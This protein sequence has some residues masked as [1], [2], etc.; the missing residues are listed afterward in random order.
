MSNFSTLN[1]CARPTLG[2]ARM[3][4]KK[5]ASAVS[6]RLVIKRLSVVAANTRVIV[7]FFEA[8]R[9]TTNGAPG[10]LAL[11]SGF[12]HAALPYAIPP[13]SRDAVVGA[14]TPAPAAIRGFSSASG[15]FPPSPGER[16]LSPPASREI[17][18]WIC[19][20]QRRASDIQVA[21]QVERIGSGGPN[22]FSVDL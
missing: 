7:T 8:D 11:E 21:R 4:V 13:R 16:N 17:G 3:V 10:A 9:E 12:L 20:C 18:R 5:M 14:A 1:A 15:S 6:N 2:T 19:T 22:E